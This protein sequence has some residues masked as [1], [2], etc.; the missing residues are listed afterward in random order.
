MDVKT[1]FFN[2]FLKEELYMMQL[3]GVV[4]PKGAKKVWPLVDLP[5]DRQAIENK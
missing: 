1:A 2:V 3:E 5:N 4:D